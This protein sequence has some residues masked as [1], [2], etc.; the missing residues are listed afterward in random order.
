VRSILSALPIL[1]GVCD[2]FAP[3]SAKSE[4]CTVV[5]EHEKHYIK[6]MPPPGKR[7]N[8]VGVHD[9]ARWR[10]LV[11]QTETLLGEFSGTVGCSFVLKTKPFGHE[12][13]FISLHICKYTL[14]DS[15]HA[16]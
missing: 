7:I 8:Y 16:G 15:P 12:F 11:G 10:E 2:H 5:V 14:G 9:E 13:G 6:I 4:A 1:I 3:E